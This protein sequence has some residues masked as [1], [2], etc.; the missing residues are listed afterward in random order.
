MKVRATET[1]TLILAFF[2]GQIAFSDILNMVRA[3]DNR[4]SDD[5]LS[6]LQGLKMNAESETQ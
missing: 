6:H 3:G 1:I 4:T 2:Q 5:A